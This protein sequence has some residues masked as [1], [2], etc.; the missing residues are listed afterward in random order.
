MRKDLFWLILAVS[1]VTIQV[2]STFTLG[3]NILIFEIVLLKTQ[4]NLQKVKIDL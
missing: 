4:T 1:S 3:Q 2:F